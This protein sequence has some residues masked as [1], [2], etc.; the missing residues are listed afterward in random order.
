MTRGRINPAWRDKSRS[1]IINPGA[2][3]PLAN[4]FIM[5][6]EMAADGV[7]KVENVTIDLAID[8]LD[9][10]GNFLPIHCLWTL[11]FVPEETVVSH[12]PQ[13]A[14]QAR[15]DS[16]KSSCMPAMQPLIAEPSSRGL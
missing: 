16:S 13:W 7:S 6:P 11:V 14:S 10:L 4:N 2:G 9:A 12:S 1:F 5:V 15:S 3:A 8:G